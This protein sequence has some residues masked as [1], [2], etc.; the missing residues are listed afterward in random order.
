MQSINFDKG[1]KKYAINNDESN[2][3]M[4]NLADTNIAK[5][6]KN[7]FAEIEEYKNTI[8]PNDDVTDA[9]FAFD[10]FV[11]EKIDNVF[12]KGV[13]KAVFGDMSCTTVA[14]ARGECVFETFLGAII[15]LIE[16]DMAEAAE[17]QRKHIKELEAK[18]AKIK[19]VIP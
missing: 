2:Y 4:V 18:A 15:P 13:S 5:R 17:N 7:I 9:M 10:Q 11:K 12:G 1:Y 3:I 16:S 14:N 8:S 19:G 6:A